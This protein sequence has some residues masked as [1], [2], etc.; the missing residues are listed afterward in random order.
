MKLQPLLSST[1]KAVDEF[2]MIQ[3][4]DKIAIGISGG[5]DSLALLYALAGLRRFYPKHFSL[6]A[7][8]VDLGFGSFDLSEIRALCETLEVPYT[9]VS[10]QIGQIIFSERG[11]KNPCSLC[12]KMRKGAF[13][14]KAKEL[15]CN[16]SAY[17]HHKDD[18]IETML[19]SL[20]YEGRFYTF[21]P[22]TYLDR[23]DITLIRPLI[24]VEEC[25]IIGFRNRYELPV[26]KNPCP[27]DGYTRREYAKNLVKQLNAENPGVKERLFRAILESSLPAWEKRIPC[28][29]GKEPG[30][31]S[32]PNKNL[33]EER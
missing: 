6:E 28:M 12:A 21:S 15:G 14:E 19:L 29:R 16:K 33:E 22:V 8:T 4:G 25:D 31:D 26:K 27:A 20:I 2:Q 32:V 13:N 17:A 5:K 11:E 3:E 23:T 18:V 7:I 9:V 24:Y 10:T 1:R 30:K